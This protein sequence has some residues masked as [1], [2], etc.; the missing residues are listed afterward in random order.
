[1]RDLSADGT[2]RTTNLPAELLACF[3]VGETGGKLPVN[4]PELDKDFQPT[5]KILWPRGGSAR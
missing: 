3:G 1:M 2:T 5:D 4:I